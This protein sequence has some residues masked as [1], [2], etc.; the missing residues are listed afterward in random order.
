[1]ISIIFRQLDHF[2]NIQDG[3]KDIFCPK[4]KSRARYARSQFAYSRKK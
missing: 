1:M 3:T 2:Q 4:Y